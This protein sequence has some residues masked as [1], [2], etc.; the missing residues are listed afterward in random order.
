MNYFLRQE[1]ADRWEGGRALILI[2]RLYTKLGER[3]TRSRPSLVWGEENLDQTR[4]QVYGILLQ[5]L[6]P[7]CDVSGSV[8]LAIGFFF[9]SPVSFVPFVS[10]SLF[11]P[12]FSPSSAPSSATGC[13]ASSPVS[14]LFSS[15][16]LCLSRYYCIRY[17]NRGQHEHASMHSTKKEPHQR[18]VSLGQHIASFYSSVQSRLSV[19]SSS[20]RSLIFFAISPLSLFLPVSLPLSS[21]LHYV[22]SAAGSLASLLFSG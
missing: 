9:P 18:V 7:S 15:L 17:K 16:F 11:L 14:S 2:T 10:F 19:P 22:M 5:G 8:N 4:R 3:L 6:F 12:L 21:M 13:L 20:L 1:M